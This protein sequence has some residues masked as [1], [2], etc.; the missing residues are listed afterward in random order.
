MVWMSRAA[1]FF[2]QRLHLRAVFPHDVQVVAAGFAGPVGL[3]VKL[4]HRPEAAETVGGEQHLFAALIADHDLRPVHHRC[5]H[6]GEGVA[7]QRQAL[8][9]LYHYTALLGHGIRPKNCSIYTKVLALPTTFMSGYLAAG[10]GNVGTMVRLHVGDHQI[11]RHAVAQRF[12]Q[13]CRQASVAR[14][15][16]VSRMATFSSRMT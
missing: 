16:T 12:G 3:F 10:A 8:A 2:Q 7:P 9:V 1:A 6:K 13:V 11:F 14:L 15:S 4:C 5:K